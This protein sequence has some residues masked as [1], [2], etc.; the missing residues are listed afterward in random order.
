MLTNRSSGRQ[1]FAIAEALAEAGAEVLLV[2]GPVALPSPSQV[3]VIRVESA[4]EMLAACR[5]ALPVDLAI[6]TAAVSDWKLASPFAGKNKKNGSQ[7]LRLDL[8]ETDDVLASI[9]RDPQRPKRIV[10]FAAETVASEAELTGLAGAK[11]RKGAD[12]W[13]RT[14]SLKGRSLT[15]IATR[16]CSTTPCRRVWSEMPSSRS[17]SSSL[18]A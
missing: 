12:S 5:Q 14:M 1:G 15:R 16:S 13:S 2:S 10:G 4:A 18:P 17:R 3:S 8:V 6:F 7:S 9:A 11:Q